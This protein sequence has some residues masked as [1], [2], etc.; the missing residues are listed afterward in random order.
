[1]T[2]VHVFD[3]GR[4]GDDADERHRLCARLL[5]RVDRSG[6]RVP[7]GEHRVEHDR[8]AV[9]EVGRELRVVLHRLERL[10]VAVHA[11]EAD[12]RARHEREH[13]VEHADA[14]A[15]HRADRHLLAG[16]ALRGHR[17]ERRLD[18]VVLGREVLRRLVREEQRDL[19]RELAEV[20]GRRLL[21]AQ[22]AELVLDE[23][24]L[25]DGQTVRLD[26]LNFV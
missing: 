16:D 10:L 1:M 11:D 3:A 15:Q 17:L 21:V 7:R 13:A 22:V 20:D 14:R 2:F 26:H 23:R 24:M 6:A 5:D 8:V 4:R 18:L 12:A 9:G 25:D 19:V